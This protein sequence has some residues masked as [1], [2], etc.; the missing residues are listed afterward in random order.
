MVSTCAI[1]QHTA[2]TATNYHFLAAQKPYQ[3]FFHFYP[4]TKKHEENFF[5]EKSGLSAEKWQDRKNKRTKN[6]S[7]KPSGMANLK[8]QSYQEDRFRKVPQNCLI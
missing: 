2:H 5:G 8:L 4:L 3:F 6:E 7:E 1:W